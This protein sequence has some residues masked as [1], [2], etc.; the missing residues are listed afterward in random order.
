MSSAPRPQHPGHRSASPG[1]R[2]VP[3]GGATPALADDS[4]PADLSRV[5]ADLESTVGFDSERSLDVA[6]RVETLARRLGEETLVWRARVVRAD[7]LERQGALAESA[8][9]LW[10]A[11][12]WAVEVG[13]RLLQARTLSLLSWT[14]RD[15]GDLATY[16]EHAVAAVELL[17]ADAP[18]SVRSTHLRRLADA[19]H[20]TGSG[21][22]AYERYLEAEQIAADVGDVPQQLSALNNLA[23]RLSTAGDADGAWAVIE[24]LGALSDTHGV[25]LRSSTLD[26]IARIQVQRGR[27]VDAEAT[28]RRAVAIYRAGADCKESDLLAQLL[29]THAVTRRHLGDLVGARH[30]VDESRGLC[31]EHGLGSVLPVVLEEESEVFAAAGDFESAWRTYRAFHAA[32]RA[33]LDD[34]R[35]RRARLRQTLFETAEARRRADVF[36]D[37]ARRDA[38][39]GLHNRRYVDEELQ[40]LVDASRAGGPGVVVG[41]VDLDHFKRVN[42]TC[43]HEVGDHVLRQVARLLEDAVA[44]PGDGCGRGGFA[45]R[46]GGEEFLVVLT[47]TGTGE[48][49]HRFEGLRA[50]VAGHDWR[51]LTGDVPVTVSIGVA[52][53]GRDSRSGLLRRADERLYEAKRAGRDRV[54]VGPGGDAGPET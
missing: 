40:G 16:L 42:D 13:E 29:V 2:V 9:L 12:A 49:L 21:A 7:V 30:A 15:A 4:S 51:G 24:R 27:F 43:S 22:A 6:D 5:M 32:E 19:L 20:E 41:L 1:S 23:Y 53:A 39:T 52:R 28:A 17:D 3:G 33:Q 36:R 26:T 35:E 54:V 46:I 50:A 45:A 48:A 8:S 38:L 47:G 18:G 34:Q 25:P 31:D 10:R 11:H 37:E 14:S 44:S